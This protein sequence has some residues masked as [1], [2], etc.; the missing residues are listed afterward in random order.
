MASNLSVSKWTSVRRLLIGLLAV[1]LSAANGGAT[2]ASTDPVAPPSRGVPIVFNA[3]DSARA[4]DVVT[5]QG[6]NFGNAP[7]VYFD[8]MPGNPLEIVNRVGTNW[9][10]V[11]IPTTAAG[12][13][14]V[15]VTNGTGISSRVLLNAAKPFH[16]DAMQ[17]VPG[18]AF[19][20]FGR[21]L[22]S[23][24]HAPLITIDG[25]PAVIDRTRSDENMLTAIAPVSLNVT[26]SAV[27]M[28]D[29]GN[30]SGPARLDRTIE[31]VAS[32]T[33]DPFSLGVGWAAGFAAIANTSLYAAT[34]PRL[35]E[36]VVCDGSHDDTPAIRAAID[37]AAS[38]GG[39]VVRLPP[40][41]CRMHNGLELKSRV[42]VMGAGK[43]ATELVYESNYPV[44]GA[45]IDL[46]GIGDLTLT[47]AGT[48]IEGS[49]LRDSTRVF[50]RNLRVHSGTSHQMY[51]T[52][53]RHF[54]VIDS[55]FVQGGSINEEGPYLLNESSGLVFTGNTT[56]WLVGAPAFRHIHDSHVRG[57]RFT[58]DGSAQ[59][60]SGMVHSLVVDFAYRVAIVG[61]QFDVVNGPITNKGR[62]DGETILTE[63]GGA[64]RT[65]NLGTVG[66][67]TATTL[68]DPL[69]TFRLDP[70]G[71]GAIPEDYGL[72]IVGGKGAGQTRRVVS[73]TGSTLTID[74]PWDVLPDAGSRYA[75]FVWGLEKSL[76]KD[77]VLS[78]NPRGIWLYQTA[79][80][81]VAIIGNTMTEGGGIFL[82]AYQNLSAKQFMPIYNVVVENNT[83][84]NS[85][86]RWMSHIEAMFVNTDARAFGIAMLGIEVRSNEITAN[87]PNVSSTLED[88]ANLEGYVNMMRV[89][90]YL[91]YETSAVPRVLG[92]IFNGN[93]C[94][95]CDVGVRVSTGAGGTTILKM[96]L[97]DSV[98]A[99][100]DSATTSSTERSTGTVYR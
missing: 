21:M 7:Q 13:L 57:N 23:R 88:Y 49:M 8:G 53:N 93:R 86:G 76:I 54:A 17:L 34:D 3:S 62:N 64:G 20:V 38:T 46:S 1:A 10:A 96:Q 89:E 73:G 79:I 47:N 78:D 26:A 74:R 67:A 81:D 24:P 27:V 68:S 9:L 29:N 71:A 43:N 33:G 32:G 84:K 100:T 58:R 40:G 66:S 2:G 14:I 15:R 30:G 37:L 39:G 18:G 92:S 6:D 45:N 98:T 90:N 4:G 5:L 80:R 16:L 50:I 42:V 59:N 95:N 83:V 55:D 48:A 22:L 97:V 36:K 87:R 41:R 75:T 85:T 51:L 52:G 44:Y 77:N 69:N 82:R 72:A 28:V 12:A 99:T 94:T 60:L 19:K 56:R 25:L 65:E 91:G 61:N 31:V 70:F 63:G 35:A 11:Q